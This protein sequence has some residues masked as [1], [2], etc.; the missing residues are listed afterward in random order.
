[1]REEA[2][3]SNFLHFVCVCER[4][5]EREYVR[6]KEERGTGNRLNFSSINLDGVLVIF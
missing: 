4:E 5:R 1:M 6:G 2:T 3:A